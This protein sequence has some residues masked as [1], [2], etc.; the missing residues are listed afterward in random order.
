VVNALEPLRRDARVAALARLLSRQAPVFAEG[1][2][3]SSA[4]IVAALAAEHLGRSLLL[5]TAHGDE[6]DDVRDDIETATGAA[7][8]LLAALEAGPGQI[9]ADDELAAERFRLCVE[10]LGA[11]SGRGAGRAAM[12]SCPPLSLGE[13]GVVIVAPIQALMQPVPSPEAIDAQCLRIAVGQKLEPGALLAALVDRGFARCDQV[14]TPGDVALR[15]GIVDVFGHA[16]SDPVRVEFFGDSV[17]SIRLFDAGTQ[18]SSQPIAEATIPAMSLAATGSKTGRVDAEQTTSFL[19]LLSAGT[20]VAFCEPTEIQE[21]GRTYWQRLG[22]RAG[23]FPVEAVLRGAGRL[24]QLHLQRF[25]GG[26]QPCVTFD[27]GALPPFA[28]RTP[29][30]LETLRELAREADVVVLCETGPEEER[31]RELL[32][33][34]HEG[35][36]G[37]RSDGTKGPRDRGTEG[38]GEGARGGGE[39]DGETER[40]TDGAGRVEESKSRSVKGEGTRSAPVATAVGVLHR[41]FVWRTAAEVT[42]ATGEARAVAGEVSGEAGALGA[43]AQAVARPRAIAFVPHHELFSRYRQRRTLRRVAPVRPIDSF[44]DLDA[45]D[46]VVHATHGIGRFRGLKSIEGAERGD[47]YLLVEFA[48]H[49][50]VHVPI[51]QIH[52]VQKYIGSVRGRPTLSRLGGTA[53]KKAKER[54][55]EAVSDLAAELLAIQAQ[56]ALQ[57][58]VAYPTDTPW[59]REFEGSFVFTE[60]ED[61]LRALAEIKRDMTQPR[62]MDRLLCG[63]VGY[64]KTEL[65]MRAAFK[66]VEYGKQAAVLVPTTVLAEQHFQTFRERMADYPF[67]VEVLSRFRTKAEQARIV[68]R[69]RKGQLDVLIGT[70]RLLSADVRFADLGLV[71]I[72]EEQRFGVEAKEKLKRLRATV[73]VLTLSATPIPRT[74]HMAMLGIRDISSLATPPLDRRA[75]VTQVRMWDERLIREAILRELNRDGQVYFVHNFVRDIHAT[76]NQI[77]SIVPEARVVVGH[78]QMAGHELEAVMLAFLK[79]EADV[80]VSTNIIESGLDIPSANTIFIN[81]ADRFGLADLHQLRGRVGRS[82]HRAYS[83]LLLSPRH[84][85]LEK[86]ARRLKAIE[87]FSELGAGFQI[88]MRDLEIRGAGNILGAEQS[89]HIEAVGYEMYCQLLE[90]AVRRLRNEPAEP[91]RP[92]NL[93][94]RITASIPRAYIR[95]EKQRMEVYKRLAS[96]RSIAEVGVLRDDLRDAYGRVPEEVETLLRLAE[97]RVLAQPWGVR[98]IV[99]EPPDVIFAID[100]LQRVQVLFAEGPGSPRVPDARTVHWRLP[101]R[102]LAADALLETVRTQLLRAGGESNGAAVGEGAAIS[103]RRAA[104]VEA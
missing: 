46:Y 55:A 37:G 76:A 47:E 67:T 14:E 75:I 95:A 57:P 6:A 24:T 102:L 89:G 20:I 17:E 58:G 93:D 63:D 23:M 91:W 5:V 104:A 103:P 31:F 101:K 71:V 87:H 1:L 73:D 26:Q 78:G 13:R 99:L 83:Y 53:W 60:T 74:L 29:E 48:G 25:A 97:V 62:P 11:G 34:R 42:G 33:E 65:A 49:A 15:G 12:P 64:G 4:P 94:L 82:K 51:S 70:H 22:E 50:Q 56:R 59:Q 8:R 21:I 41:G 85:V 2:W 81:R 72:D 28:P 92:V 84:P 10:I 77:R 80:L 35:T 52:V 32:E 68:E 100:D 69:A 36:E 3:G 54:V 66:T 30:A 44:F 39:R 19:T 96:A 9:D 43:R 38:A 27:V 86:A 16:A 90:Q 61:Q 98:S 88:A 45:G 7:P 40:R 79:R 18:R